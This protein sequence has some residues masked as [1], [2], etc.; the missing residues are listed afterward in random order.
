MF[1][2]KFSL[3]EK[4]SCEGSIKGLLTSV[5]IHCRELL[6]GWHSAWRLQKEESWKTDWTDKKQL[7]RVKEMQ[8]KASFCSIQ[9]PQVCPMSSNA[10]HALTSSHG[11]KRWLG[12]ELKARITVLYLGYMNQ[13]WTGCSFHKQEPP[14]YIA[15]SAKILCR[16]PRGGCS[17][18]LKFSH[19]QQGHSAHEVL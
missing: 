19:C 5:I 11:D 8:V 14:N 2:P 1:F 4:F 17:L 10:S 13:V 7:Q 12:K 6:H 9:A 16:P 3:K 18:W 15:V